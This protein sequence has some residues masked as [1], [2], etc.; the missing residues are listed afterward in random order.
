MLSFKQSHEGFGHVAAAG[1]GPQQQQQPWWAGSQLLYGEASPEEAA[2]R[3]GG[4]FQVVPG[5]RAA[6][7]P[8]A[9]EPEKTAVPAMP[10]RGGGGGAPEVLKFSVFSGEVLCFFFFSSLSDNN[11]KFM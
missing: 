1:A 4:Q 2:L 3:D 7:D 6:L 11:N 9:P 5:G 8:A 10:K